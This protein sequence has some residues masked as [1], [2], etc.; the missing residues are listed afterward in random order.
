MTRALLLLLVACASTPAAATHH[1]PV[2][3]VRGEIEAAETA[4]KARQ[5][6]VARV[7]YEAAVAAAKDPE[8]IAFARR[9][10]AETLATWGETSAA[11]AQLEVVVGVAPNDPSAW[12]DLGIIRHHEGDIR[13][14]IA[15]LGRAEELA[16]ADPRPKIALAALYWRQRDKPNATREYQKL[17]ELDL[18]PR[19]R[20]KVQWA[21]AELA[22]P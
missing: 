11:R 6:D 5:H 21:L 17:L 13:G 9:E 2:P 19:L 15:A 12:H 4:E 22:K 7:H 18:P 14:A 16:P 3:T 1:T 10:Y 20:E 8:S